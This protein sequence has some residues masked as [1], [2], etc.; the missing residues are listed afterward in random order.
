MDQ[1]SECAPDHRANDITRMFFFFGCTLSP[2]FGG[3]FGSAPPLAPRPVGGE[4]DHWQ[5]IAEGHSAI[6]YFQLPIKASTNWARQ[7]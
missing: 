3:G 6:A 5:H 2:P 4:G 7:Q 1:V